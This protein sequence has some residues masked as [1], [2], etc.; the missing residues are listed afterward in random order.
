MAALSSISE[1]FSSKRFRS[2]PLSVLEPIMLRFLELC[3]DLRKGRTAKDGL[4]LY[5]NVA[6]NTSVQ[7]VEVTI[8]KLL[9]LS[10]QKLADALAKVEELEGGADTTAAAK[11]EGGKAA[12]DV[13]DLEATETPESILLGA[14]SDDK[15]RDRTY[16]ALVTPWLRFLWESYRTALDILR[17][18]A[19][20]ETLYQTVC[21]DAFQ[22]CLAHQR[23]TE[24]RRLCETL[25]SH[26]ASS[27]K[28]THQSH[29]INLND[30]DTLQRH[31][32]TR[33]QQLSTAVELELWQEAFRT[34][35]DIHTLV[36]MSK[37]APK[38]PVMASFYDKMA[39]V[40]AVG[41][42]FLFHAAAYGKLYSLH[43]A[44]LALQGGDAKG[45][46]GELE[47]LASR[48]LLSALAVPV[49]SGV[50]E[51]GR[52]RSAS[53][54]GPT[55][56]GESKGR[57]GRLASLI[58][59]ATPPTRAGLIHDALSRHALKRVSPQLRE[60]Y[61]ILE[62]DFHPL[63]ITAKID[64]ILAQ[65]EQQPDTARYVAPLK[66]VVLA[67]LFQQLAQVYS[68]LKLDRVVKLASFQADG[69][70][71][72]TRR[73]VERYVTEACRRGDVDVTIDHASG[74]IRFD[75]ALFGDEAAASAAGHDSV[76]TLQPSAAALLRSHL[77]RL[78]TTLH[79]TLNAVA[80]TSQSQSPA[81][82]AA[83]AREKAFANLTA[84]VA[85]ERD[86][87]L[88][89]TMIIKRRKELAEEQNARKEQED[90]HAR[91]IRAQQK[92]EEDARRQKE[93]LRQRELDRIKREMEKVKQDEAKKVAESL[94]QSGLKVD[95]Q[96]LPELSANDLVQL[97]VQQ[98]EKDKKDLAQKLTSVHKRLDHLERAFRREEIPLIAED[99]KRQ[100]LRDREAF[101]SAQVQRS[102][103]ARQK[104]TRGL[105][106]KASLQRIMPDYAS[107]RERQ[108]RESREAYEAERR[109]L[110]EQL[111]EAKAER[112][113]QILAD[114]E[115][116]RQAEIRRQQEEEER[117]V[118]E[119]EQARIRAE[120]EAREAEERAKIEER[121]RQAAA[122]A[123]EA[124][125]KALEE[126][127]A[128]RKAD[129]ERIQ[130]QYRREEE[131]LARRQGRPAAPSASASAATVGSAAWRAQRDAASPA[132]STPS[133][134]TERPR[135]PL[136]PRTG[137]GDA[138]SAAAGGERP[139]LN[140]QPRNSGDGSSSAGG[141]RPR[142]QLQPRSTPRAEAPPVPSVPAG[143]GA[144]TPPSGKDDSRSSSPAAGGAPG[145]YVPPSRAGRAPSSRW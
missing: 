140:L 30:P 18:N 90:A 23:K 130:A 29:S 92:A 79:S 46:D 145:K 35:E 93:E 105:A 49:G 138:P 95:K 47:K 40:F 22:F 44:R 112:R 142:M 41:D 52:G 19:R 17:N 74:S 51:T 3:V 14:V 108:E 43:S 45:E 86:T 120:Q 131:A 139:R 111:A 119:E 12:V 123:E 83:A 34:A 107:F 61:Q 62:V 125:K 31:L 121:Q 137:S 50:V 117:R 32:D 141:E 114:R 54:D 15:S 104:H 135:L 2:T 91:S 133:S 124:R 39:K 38:G 89:R 36:G 77:A 97:Q 82:V 16:R 63:S 110:D 122:E 81:Q 118:R 134:S 21:H 101:E 37:R 11:A 85:D 127:L 103:E 80:S 4:I 1:V 113:R 75:Q 128:Q 20:L 33:F 126:R 53:A 5:K 65:L 143:T 96:K 58:G 59:L 48:V 25:R 13:D 7:S 6:Q 132:S 115:A 84:A 109:R 71:D 102:E 26:L 73:R 60:L 98:I 129:Q 57:L 100:Q 68:S 94:I 76:Q 106:I 55:E 10:R 64:P 67:R 27:Q 24:F 78:A 28:Y 72:V 87:V 69:D 136:Q 88:A 66:E 116:E 144:N 99:Y 70:R 56:E 9:S 8:N 42:N